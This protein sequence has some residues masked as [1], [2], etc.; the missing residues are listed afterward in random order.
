MRYLYQNKFLFWNLIALI[1]VKAAFSFSG[2]QVASLLNGIA[3]FTKEEILTQTNILRTS[4]GF[5]ELKESPL[6]DAA[7]ADK[8][9]DMIKNGYFAHTS[10]VGV[11]PWF[12]IEKNRYNFNYAGENLAIGFSSARETV[13]AWAD[14]PSHRDNLLN[15]RYKEMGI[16]VAQAKVDGTDGILVVQ[17][18]GTPRPT[19][20]VA[21]LAKPRPATTATTVKPA[22]TTTSVMI[23]TTT[24]VTASTTTF[25]T[26]PSPLPSNKT[27]GAT[28]VKS[29]GN[30]DLATVIKITD[31]PRVNKMARSLNLAFAS[32]A[33]IMA[34]ISAAFVIF[35][36]ARKELV[37]RAS[38]SLALFL[39]AIVVPFVQMAHRALIL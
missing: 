6:L 39:L 11:S 25:Q 7:A 32:Y 28:V 24:T 5:G 23:T 37:I 22:V 21:T 4:L 9:Q 12:W 8:L 2:I 3:S 29:E 1:I 16:A 30:S 13:N 38:A 19:K 18:F 35:M 15:S 27:A 34:L 14:S 17:M 20:T 36:G 31:S 33:L 10:P 26:T